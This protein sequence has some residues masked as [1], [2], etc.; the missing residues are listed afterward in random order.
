[1]IAFLPSRS[2]FG[3]DFLFPGAAFPAITSGSISATWRIRTASSQSSIA[4]PAVASSAFGMPDLESD[5]SDDDE[6]IPGVY[7]DPGDFYQTEDDENE[8][9]DS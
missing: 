1:M 3:E 8:T 7:N 2:S 4:A 5:D 9:E 6:N